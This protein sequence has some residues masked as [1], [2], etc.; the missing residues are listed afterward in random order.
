MP[1]FKPGH[2]VSCLQMFPT[3]SPIY[4]LCHCWSGDLLSFLL[5]LCRAKL[6]EADAALQ[7]HRGRAQEAE[8][9]LPAYR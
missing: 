8:A 4:R 9:N 2:T 6:R 5:E 1:A 3:H 7:G